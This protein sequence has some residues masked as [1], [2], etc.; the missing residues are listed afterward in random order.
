MMWRSVGSAASISRPR[1]HMASTRPSTLGPSASASATERVGRTRELTGD[2]TFRY[3]FFTFPPRLT[4][5]VP[6]AGP[7]D[8]RHTRHTTSR[9]RD[10]GVSQRAALTREEAGHFA[11]GIVCP[12]HAWTFDPTSG[13]GSPAARW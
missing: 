13:A 11:G 12:Y 8:R 7:T 5:P 9:E 4:S 2:R 1:V 6:H 3:M 10:G